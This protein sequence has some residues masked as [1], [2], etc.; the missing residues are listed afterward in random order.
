MTVERTRRHTVVVWLDTG[1]REPVEITL[2]NRLDEPTAIH[3]HGMELESYYDGVHGWSGSRRR[4]TPIIEP[5]G[6][7]VVR[8]TPPRAGTFIYHTHLHDYRQLSSGLY[9]PLIVTDAGETFDPATDH[10]IVIGRS[11]LT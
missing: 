3:W 11:G 5:G 7:F 2:M 8:F 4:V 9:G 1:Q 10:V 6:S